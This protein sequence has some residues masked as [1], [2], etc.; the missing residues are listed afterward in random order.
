MKRLIFTVVLFI[1]FVVILIGFMYMTIQETQK[2]LNTNITTSYLNHVKQI[3]NNIDAYL[4]TYIQKDIYATL[5]KDVHLRD[6]LQKGLELVV[7]DP[8]KYVYILYRDPKGHYRYLLDGSHDEKGFFDQKFDVNLQA[9]NRAYTSGADT[10]ITH[11]NSPFLSLTYLHP[12]RFAKKVEAIAAIDFTTELPQDIK[13]ILAPLQKEITSIFA[14]FALFSTL[15]ALQLYLYYKTR[16]SSFIDPLTHVYNRSFLKPFL[17]SIDPS[18]YAIVMVDIDHFKKIN[19]TYGH[20]AGDYVLQSVSDILKKNLRNH[21]VIIRYGGE[22]FLLFLYDPSRNPNRII[23]TVERLRK[24]LQTT[25]LHYEGHTI[26]VTASFGITLRPDHFRSL[27]EAI[28]YADEKLYHAKRTGRNRIEYSDNKEKNID[29][30]VLHIVQTALDN[31]KILCYYQPIYDIATKTPQKYEALVRLEKDGKI[32]YPGNFLE[33]IAYTTLY[34]RLTKRILEIV[35]TT[36]AQHQKHI[37]INLN[38]SD[39]SDNVIYTM[40]QDTIKANRSWAHFLTIELLENEP[41]RDSSLMR[42]KLQNFK[43]LGITIAIDD[44]GSGYSNFEIFRHLPIDILKVD[45]TIIKSITTSKIS[46]SMAKAIILFAK[47][48]GIETV[49]EFVENEE[50]FNLLQQLG[51]DYAQGYYLSRPLAELKS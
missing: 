46:L 38:F 5:K 40:I 31:D 32:L 8:Y 14:I 10:I 30:D 18:K 34:T 17:E 4:H 45:G 48:N 16:K 21:D 35:F 41:L 26:N 33:H 50:I 19:D 22:E 11:K 36:I 51:F 7:A 28:K 39:I 23:A 49:G 9:W 13:Q 27:N 3:A 1:L 42:E 29:D 20:K 6:Q 25:P 37:S 15:L 24:T 2:E 12:L 43:E 44:F 47:E